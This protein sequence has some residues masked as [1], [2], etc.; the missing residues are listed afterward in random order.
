MHIL[1]LFKEDRMRIIF[2]VCKWYKT[3]KAYL[4]GTNAKQTPSCACVVRQIQPIILLIQVGWG[5]WLLLAERHLITN[6]NI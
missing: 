6:Q 2:P 4:K 5:L 1:W 3:P